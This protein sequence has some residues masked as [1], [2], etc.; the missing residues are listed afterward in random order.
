[1]L[2]LDIMQYVLEPM[3]TNIDLAIIKNDITSLTYNEKKELLN[4]SKSL[5][6]F[7][8]ARENGCPWD[9]NT[10]SNAALNGHFEILKWARKNGC[11]WDENTCTYAALNGHL[12]IFKWACENCWQTL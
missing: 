6:M 3:L 5:S 8:W 11:P 10:C 9:K 12:E 1:M 4:D 2:P 7:K